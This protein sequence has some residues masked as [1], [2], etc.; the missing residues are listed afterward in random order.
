M[1]TVGPGSRP[2]PMAGVVVQ[3]DDHGSGDVGRQHDATTPR[4]IW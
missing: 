2:K 3:D 1:I 4:S